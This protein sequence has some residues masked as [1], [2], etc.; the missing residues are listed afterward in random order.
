MYSAAQEPAAL[1]QSQHVNPWRVRDI[2]HETMLPWDENS[3]SKSSV[4]AQKKKN[5]GKQNRHGRSLKMSLPY[6]A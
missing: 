1:Q 2:C 3:L 6:K 4:Q 5:V